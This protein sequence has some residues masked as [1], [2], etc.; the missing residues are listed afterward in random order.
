MIHFMGS[1]CSEKSVFAAR[2]KTKIAVL[3]IFLGLGRNEL[4]ED[5]FPL[6]IP[7]TIRRR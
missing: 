7:G 5:A 4:I 3:S 1:K 6:F 2:E